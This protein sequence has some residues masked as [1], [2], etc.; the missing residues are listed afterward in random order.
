MPAA[1]R[2][3]SAAQERLVLDLLESRERQH[4][5]GV[6]V[7]QE[8]PERHEQLAVPRVAAVHLHVELGAVGTERPHH[9]DAG[10]TL[11]V[12]RLR[13]DPHAGEAEPHPLERW[14]PAG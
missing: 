12:E 13:V 1:C 7:P 9:S 5:T 4:R 6:A 3:S 2:R 14:Q 10:P 8:A 11:H